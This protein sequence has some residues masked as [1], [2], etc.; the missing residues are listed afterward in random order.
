MESAS[1]AIRSSQFPFGLTAPQRR[2][3]F[4]T[5]IESRPTSPTALRVGRFS[6]G[7]ESGGPRRVGRF[8]DGISAPPSATQMHRQGSFADGYRRG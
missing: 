8:S 3:R 1:I 6:Q 5:G 4:S 2:G 7:V